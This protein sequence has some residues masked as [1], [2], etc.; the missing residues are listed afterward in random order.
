[1]TWLVFIAVRAASQRLLEAA[2][3]EHGVETVRAVIALEIALR[4][5]EG[6]ATLR[7]PTD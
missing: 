3:S 4:E 1:M 7:D 2:L 5:L 6:A